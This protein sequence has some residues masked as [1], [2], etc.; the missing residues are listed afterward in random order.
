M[1]FSAAALVGELLSG[2][3]AAAVVGPPLQLGCMYLAYM[4]PTSP[5]FCIAHCI[6]CWLLHWS[7]T[8]SQLQRTHCLPADWLL[9]CSAGVN[10]HEHDQRRGKTVSLE[11]MVQVGSRFLPKQSYC[12]MI[13][14]FAW[15]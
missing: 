2:F 10:R 5:S 13:I 9:P 12:T 4:A 7:A 15:L 8:P 14:D 6:L 1:G 11:G 3:S